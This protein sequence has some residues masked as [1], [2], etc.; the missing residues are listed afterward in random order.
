MA[1]QLADPELN[2]GKF[3]FP[4]VEIQMRHYLSQELPRMEFTSHWN[5]LNAATFEMGDEFHL[6]IE[7][8]PKGAMHDLLKRVKEAGRPYSVYKPTEVTYKECSRD[9]RPLETVKT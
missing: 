2:K 5:A 4:M 6:L 7:D 3:E 8:Y 9:K 1:L